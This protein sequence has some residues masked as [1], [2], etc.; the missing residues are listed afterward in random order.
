MLAEGNVE[1]GE[2]TIRVEKKKCD[3]G[4]HRSNVPC[5]LVLWRVGS[6]KMKFLGD[7]EGLRER[8]KTLR[9]RFSVSIIG[10]NVQLGLRRARGALRF[11]S[12]SA[13]R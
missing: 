9:F 2:R 3:R 12:Y 7:L 6:V 11:S 1:C 13:L 8:R 10:S 5:N 4:C